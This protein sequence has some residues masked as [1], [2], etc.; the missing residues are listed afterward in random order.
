MIMFV[1]SEGKSM[2]HSGTNIA[3]RGLLLSCFLLVPLLFSPEATS[4]TKE[5]TV[6]PVVVSARVKDGDV[7]Y[8]VNGKRVED[9]RKNSLLTNLGDILKSRGNEV[10]VFIVI[11]VRARIS[12]V[13][14]LETALDK[15]GLIHYRL[16]VSN[17][18]DNVMNELHWD[19]TGIPIPSGVAP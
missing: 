15:V 1:T 11:D 10:P 12:E 4:Q 13:G 6:Q 2:K 5:R 18:R 17:F 8:R 3:I 19:E 9:S 16:F 14:K 7:I